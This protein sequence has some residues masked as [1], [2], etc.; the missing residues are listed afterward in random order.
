MVL[1]LNDELLMCSDKMIYKT[2]RIHN[3]YFKQNSLENFFFF[4]IDHT[5]E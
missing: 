5:L 2:F 4:T 3:N 1:M